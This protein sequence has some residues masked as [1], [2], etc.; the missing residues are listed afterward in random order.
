[1]QN[2]TTNETESPLVAQGVDEEIVES[3]RREYAPRVAKIV[4][5]I[6]VVYASLHMLALN[7]VS[8]SG[9]TGGMINLPFL[10]TLPTDV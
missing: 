3:N 9:M 6:A 5:G 1:M 4:V 2:Q 7:G 8:I 10:Q